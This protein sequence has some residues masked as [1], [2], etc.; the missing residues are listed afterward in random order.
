MTESIIKK[1]QTDENIQ[2]KLCKQKEKKST[3]ER[4]I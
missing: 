1:R 3:K 4:E 2:T